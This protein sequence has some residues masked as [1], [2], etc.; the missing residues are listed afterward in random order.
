M[1]QLRESKTDKP[2]TA[3]AIITIGKSNNKA[4]EYCR[5]IHL[6]KNKLMGLPGVTEEGYRHG[7][8]EVT[9]DPSK[10]RY[11]STMRK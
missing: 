10:G 4:K 6:P 1:A 9:I 7:Y 2:A 8:F 3:D 5:F 11:I